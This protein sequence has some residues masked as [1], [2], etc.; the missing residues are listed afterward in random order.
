M[1]EMA[2]EQGS[3]GLDLQRYLNIA[4]RRHMQF[5]VP[6]FVGWLLVWS[7]SWVLPPRYKSDTTILVDPS[8]MPK[9]YVQ[10]NVVDDLQARLQSIKQQVLSRTRLLLIIDKLHL[11]DG[12]RH[13]ADDDKVALMGK[14]IDIEL[15]Q[16]PN[17]DQI[18]GFKISYS[19]HNPHVAQAVASEL[20]GLFINENGKVRLQESEN[21]TKF[22]ASQ[23]DAARTRLAEQEAK[24]R[25]FKSA[26]E[27]ALPTQQASNLQI[28]AGYQQEL[29]NEQDALN[30][31]RQQQSL[32]RTLIEQ[33][34][35]IHVTTRTADG[36]PA[37]LPALDQ[38]LDTLR[39]KLA[40]LSS[41][42]TDNYPDVQSLKDQIARTEKMRDALAKEL[43]ERASSKQQGNAP[44]D[45]SETEDLATNGPLMQLKGQLQ[46]NELEIANREQAILALKAKINDYQTRLNQEPANDQ[47]LTDLNRGY[48]QSKADYDELVKKKNDS[49]MATSMEQMQQGERFTILDAASL[50]QKPDFPNRLKF[51]GIGLGAGVGL[52]LVVVLGLEFLD[53]RMHGEKEIKSLLP[54]A[55][56]SEIPAVLSSSDERSIRNRT[57]WRWTATAVVLMIILAGSAVSYLRN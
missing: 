30:S 39:S 12:D 48:D 19:S 56:I 22:L 11:Y 31:A 52:G 53:D 54:V 23:L 44:A 43:K 26:H 13:L 20:A 51:C 17:R 41:R 10:P 4:Q 36:T 14:D 7:A 28:L 37:G 9:D 50:P 32:D 18:N 6:A 47:A 35:S 49:E 3:G 46:A 45:A 1:A 27:G 29:Q 5:L 40:D 21:T 42:Y 8:T 24:V 33:Y 55:V 16:D 2:E 38:Q 25:E 34:R 57:V 15:V